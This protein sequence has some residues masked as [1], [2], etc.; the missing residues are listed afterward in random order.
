MFQLI[1]LMSNYLPSE[2]VIPTSK[3]YEL[4]QYNKF[5]TENLHPRCKLKLCKVVHQGSVCK[6]LL[7]VV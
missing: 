6:I 4:L 2:I 5:K 7:L 1:D 3:F